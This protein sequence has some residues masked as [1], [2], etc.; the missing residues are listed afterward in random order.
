MQY[1]TP[2][3]K[4][5]FK[6]E[7]DGIANELYSVDDSLKSSIV[8][9]VKTTQALLTVVPDTKQ[10]HELVDNLSVLQAEALN[11]QNQHKYRDAIVKKLESLTS[12]ENSAVSSLRNRAL[13]QVNEEVLT[14]LKTDKKFKEAALNQAV[15]VLSAGEGTKYGK[16][17]VAETY[18]AALKKYREDYA[19]QPAGSDKIIAQLEKDVE[20]II[21]APE[22]DTKVGNVYQTNPVSARYVA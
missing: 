8:E 3:I 17:L 4:K 15:A 5:Y 10:I 21:A 7:I 22:V 18:L 20:A 6:E 19:K 16:D 11:S 14:V 12:L 13:K 9:D 2:G 1:G